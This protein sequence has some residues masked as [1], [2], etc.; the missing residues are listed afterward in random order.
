MENNVEIY[1]KKM[2]PLVKQLV[3]ICQQHNMPILV[4]LCISDSEIDD[5][6]REGV[7]VMSHF[8][9]SETPPHFHLANAVLNAG[10]TDIAYQ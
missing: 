8:F 4:G 7:F 10:G 3:E 9:P 1:K 2:S 6:K 5:E